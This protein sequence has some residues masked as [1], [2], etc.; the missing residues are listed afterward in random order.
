MFD[1]W[2]IFRSDD[3]LVRWLRLIACYQNETKAERN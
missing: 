1:P 3:S 2:H